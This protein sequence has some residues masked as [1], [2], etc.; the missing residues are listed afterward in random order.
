MNEQLLKQFG[1][2]IRLAKVKYGETQTSLAVKCG[3]SDRTIGLLESGKIKNPRTMTIAKIVTVLRLDPN[4]WLPP[5][6]SLPPEEVVVTLQHRLFEDYAARTGAF[7]RQRLKVI[8]TAVV[9]VVVEIIEERYA[10]KV[11][12]DKITSVITRYLNKLD[13]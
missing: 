9:E 10:I 11:D 8:T 13:G 7:S 6:G 5:E 4:K 3:L 2:E 12:S 1:T